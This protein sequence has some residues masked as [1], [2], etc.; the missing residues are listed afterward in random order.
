MTN[1]V[2]LHGWAQTTVYPAGTT[3]PSKAVY[4]GDECPVC[5]EP[6]REGESVHMVTEKEFVDEWVHDRHLQKEGDGV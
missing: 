6:M 1:G 2:K 5:L 4:D 3:N